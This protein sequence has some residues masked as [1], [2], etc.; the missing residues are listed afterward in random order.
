M[1]RT[2]LTIVLINRFDWAVET[3][4]KPGVFSVEKRNWKDEFENLE[5]A[6]HKAWEKDVNAVEGFQT[7]GTDPNVSH[8]C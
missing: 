7:D 4:L 2:V 6:K 8:Y 5:A 1:Q 3:P